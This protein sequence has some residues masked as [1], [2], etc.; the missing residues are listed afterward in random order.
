LEENTNLSFCGDEAFENDLGDLKESKLSLD[1][2]KINS[3]PSSI[4]QPISKPINVPIKRNYLNDSFD[5]IISPPD[6][7]QE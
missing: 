4:L 5:D 7:H 3:L 2:K 6:E 1:C